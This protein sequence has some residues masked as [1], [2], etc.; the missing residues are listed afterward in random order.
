MNTVC[1][2]WSLS[3]YSLVGQLKTVSGISKEKSKN[4]TE[5]KFSEEEAGRQI[6]LKTYKPT[7]TRCN[8]GKKK[9]EE[10]IPAITFVLLLVK[11][12]SCD[13]LR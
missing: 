8:T 3:E 13:M 2:Y 9:V 10:E 12:G 4:D 5:L 6:V 1:N 11:N 7:W